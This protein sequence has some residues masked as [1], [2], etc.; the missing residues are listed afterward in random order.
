M[1][2]KVF[3]EPDICAI[4]LANA[5]FNDELI[6]QTC[7]EHQCVLVTNDADFKEANIDILTANNKLS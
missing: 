3:N 5:D 1:I 2:G 4:D 7:Q 6:I